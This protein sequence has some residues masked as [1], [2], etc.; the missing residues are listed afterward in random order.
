YCEGNQLGLFRLESTSEL[1]RGRFGV[2]EPREE[3]RKTPGKRIGPEEV[4]MYL[5]PGVAFDLSGRRLGWGG[6]FF[7]RFLSPG[8]GTALRVGVAYGEQIVEEIPYEEHDCGVE[9]LITPERMIT[10]PRY[11]DH[12]GPS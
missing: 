4:D 1:I 5:I 12:P 11:R 6:G 9:L 7:D 3:L 2:P 8:V 10:V